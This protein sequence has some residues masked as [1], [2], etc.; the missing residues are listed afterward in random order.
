ML[1]LYNEGK[2]SLSVAD[3]TRG[4]IS[5]VEMADLSDGENKQ[6]FL[7]RL[8]V[9]EAHFEDSTPLGDTLIQYGNADAPTDVSNDRDYAFKKEPGPPN[10]KLETEK[11]YSAAKI[12]ALKKF[13]KEG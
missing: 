11:G 3:L 9:L 8:F 2:S 6:V 13:V 5:Y 4:I 10:G 12:T 1:L 7:D